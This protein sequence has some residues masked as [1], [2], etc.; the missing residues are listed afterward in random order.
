MEEKRGKKISDVIVSIRGMM[1]NLLRDKGGYVRARVQVAPGVIKYVGGTSAWRAAGAAAEKAKA[2]A[3]AAARA[4]AIAEAK[5]KAELERARQEAAR[6]EAA[7]KALAK[8]I[9]DKAIARDKVRQSISAQIKA[10]TIF[11]L[12][13]ETARKEREKI[14]QKPREAFGKVVAAHQKAIAQQKAKE[15]SAE[16]FAKKVIK[17]VK[18]AI[19]IL[20]KKVIKAERKFAKTGLGKVVD[21]VSGGTLTEREISREKNKLYENYEKFNKRYG[22]RELSEKEFDMAKKEEARLNSESKRIENKEAKF[23]ESA[24]RKIGN[25]V[26]REGALTK[27]R[28]LDDPEYIKDVLK[29][30][31]KNLDKI[32]RKLENPKLTKFAKNLLLKN[33][34]STKKTISSLRAGTPPA[35]LL[36][37]PLPILPA[38]GIPRNIK[39]GFVGT[40]KIKGNKIITDVV[41]KVGK[42]RVGIAR[43]V[44]ITKG[45]KGTSVVLGKSG[46]K[47][48]KFPSGKVK[49]GRQEVFVGVEKIDV[50]P[51]KFVKEIGK[52]K[53]SKAL[54]KQLKLPRNIVIQQNIK[55][56]RQAGIGKVATVKGKTFI[57]PSGKKV[58]GVSV[59][60]FISTSKVLTR[61]DL[62]LIIGKSIT[63]NKDKVHFIGLIKGTS[64]IGKAYRLTGV[65]QQQYKAALGKVTSVIAAATKKV[66]TV[67]GL[68]YVQR[69]ALTQ[70]VIQDTIKPVTIRKPTP[71][72]IVKPVTKPP[73]FKPLV[74]QKQI[75]ETKTRVKQGISQISNQ[76]QKVKQKIAQI[77]RARQK[78]KTKVAQKTLQQQRQKL[79]LRLK[80]LQ[81]QKNVLTSIRISP[82]FVPTPKQIRV[83]LL[84]LPKI[85]KIKKKVKIK[86]IKP[87]SYHVYARP[88]RKK[89]RKI[90]KLIRVTKRP[91]RKSRAKD[92]RNYLVDTSLSRTAK[93]KPSPRKPSKRILKAPTGYASKTKKKFRKYKIVK[94]KRKTL[95]SGKVI[96]RRRHLLDTKQEKKQITLRKRIAQL[97][98]QS[99]K[100]VR[101]NPTTPLQS[102]YNQKLRKTI[103]RKATPQQ[104]MN[105][106]KGRDKLARMRRSK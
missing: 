4:K 61:K 58:T 27:G 17:E 31:E 47:G 105:L 88:L 54:R 25:V 95:P 62:S 91:I 49:L 12:A 80:Q 44:T 82:K 13:Q 18:E 45:T 50:K 1:G 102:N 71:V 101:K 63:S 89:G 60:D 70:R 39:V 38:F 33:K 104:L 6:K 55:G 98:K 94:G 75:A 10:R 7:R 9:F 73:I 41:F 51:A 29:S 28:D 56:F 11:G 3:K 16:E 103:K 42:K 68:S 92:L 93:L 106:K 22:G 72:Q 78:A 76:Q 85:K 5:A 59:K 43:G 83:L 34:E 74:T 90:P 30:W 32:N 86:K 96:E 65:Q 100:S 24:V 52:V 69:V 19:P 46:V 99:K 66:D 81:I 67:K 20:E 97:Q 35:F 48:L 21:I 36:G 87:R 79:R 14:I 8:A 53:V 40:Q 15:K 64:D 84:P 2:A 77:T 37:E 23:R 26:W 57:K